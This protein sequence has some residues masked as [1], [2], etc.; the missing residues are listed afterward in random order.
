MA[1]G[2][3][4]DVGIDVGASSGVDSATAVGTAV[5]V[6][7]ATVTDVGADVDVATTTGT[8]L[9]VAAGAPDTPV[10]VGD[11]TCAAGRISLDAGAASPQA[12]PA[13]ATKTT[14]ITQAI[15]QTYRIPKTLSPFAP[16]RLCVKP[17]HANPASESAATCARLAP[18]ARPPPPDPSFQAHTRVAAAY[19]DAPTPRSADPLSSTLPQYDRCE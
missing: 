12:T 14:A 11:A 8:A 1:V 18:A 19:S 6:A 4:V 16:L 5:A 17:P 9:G 3:G 10:C 2:A 7:A 15:A 13:S